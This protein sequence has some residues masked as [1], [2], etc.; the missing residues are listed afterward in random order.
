M[1]FSN[2]LFTVRRLLKALHLSSD[3][4]LAI[5]TTHARTATLRVRIR[6]HKDGSR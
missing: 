6:T 3:G 1:N 4:V 5:Q 2:I